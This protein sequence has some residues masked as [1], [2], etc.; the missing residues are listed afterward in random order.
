MYNTEIENTRQQIVEYI[1]TFLGGNLV[2]VNLTP[3]IIMLP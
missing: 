3:L 2:D 1:R